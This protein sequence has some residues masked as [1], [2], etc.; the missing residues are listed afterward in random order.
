MLTVF[1]VPIA[2][3][4][5]STRDLSPV[6]LLG[7]MTTDETATGDPFD[8]TVKLDA[9]GIEVVCRYSL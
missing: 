9:R 5:V 4:N 6:V 8:R 1:P 3:D 7:P 2:E